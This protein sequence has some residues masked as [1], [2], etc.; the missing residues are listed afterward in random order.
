M[1]KG[2]VVEK[3]KFDTLL[4]KMLQTPPM[5][6]ADIPRKRKKKANAAKA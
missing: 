6:K 3:S 5:P 4:K 1:R 2:V